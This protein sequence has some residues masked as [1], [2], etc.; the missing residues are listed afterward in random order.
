MQLKQVKRAKADAMNKAWRALTPKQQFEEL[1][2]RP[3]NSLK[4]KA[5]I[6]GETHAITP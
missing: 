4:Q 3:G 2:K 5:R 6:Q 1:N